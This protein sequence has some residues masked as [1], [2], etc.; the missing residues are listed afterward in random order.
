MNIEQFEYI[1]AIAKTGSIS[2]AAEQLHV[3][4]AAISKSVA[5]L[6]EEL[7]FK[8][9]KR[10]RTGTAVTPRGAIVIEKAYRI[11]MT[12]EEIKEEAQIEKQMLDGEVRFSI[13]PNFM[14]VLTKSIITFK[15]AHPNVELT[16]MSK[17]TEDVLEDL[18]EDRADLGLIYLYEQNEELMKELVIHKIMDSRMV[19]CTGKGTPLA[20]KKSVTPQELLSYPF[21][22][23][24]G[25]F[26]N[27]YLEDFNNKY[28]PVQLIFKSNNIELLKRTI[29]QD[30]AIGIFI[31]YSMLND[32][33]VQNGDIAIVPLIDHEPKH[34]T[35]GW[36]ISVHKHFSIAQKEF[37][38]H[39]LHEYHNLNV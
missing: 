31:E 19:V 15:Q 9:F 12:I 24:D 39:L 23:I 14:A 36:A 32:P 16:I 4:Q 33:F 18:N 21:V 22:N 34:I 7:G 17:S 5:R 29:A 26:S 10:S 25:K 3:S 6:E 27:W 8:L 38:K 35:L 28:G 30:M 11:L 37:I 2:A 1:N 13:G 20:S